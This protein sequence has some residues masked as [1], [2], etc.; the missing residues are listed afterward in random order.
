MVGNHQGHQPLPQ[1][2]NPSYDQNMQEMY[3]YGQAPSTPTMESQMVPGSAN[4]SRLSLWKLPQDGAENRP[5]G[6]GQGPNMKSG[7]KTSLIVLFTK[8]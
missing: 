3:P 5:Q 1:M 6:G 2:N 4:K 7:I 8:K